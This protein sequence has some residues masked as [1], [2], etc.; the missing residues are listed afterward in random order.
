MGLKQLQTTLKK[1]FSSQPTTNVRR[2]KRHLVQKVSLNLPKRNQK[3]TNPALLRSRHPKRL[4]QKVKKVNLRQELKRNQKSTTL[5]NKCSKPLTTIAKLN[6]H[7]LK[8]L[9][10]KK[11]KRPGLPKKKK[12]K[13]KKK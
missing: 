8:N 13:K 12:K 2:L 4:T 11:K 10:K 3:I 9:V 5:K 7:H 6:Y 1:K